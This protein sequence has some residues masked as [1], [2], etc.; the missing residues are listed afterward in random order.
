MFLNI[1]TKLFFFPPKISFLLQL[2]KP[3]CEDISQADPQPPMAAGQALHRAFARAVLMVHTSTRL[4]LHL[5][6]PCP[7][8]DLAQWHLPGPP[9]HEALGPTCESHRPRVSVTLP[10]T[11]I[12]K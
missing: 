12:R 6:N 1:V 9:Q 11:Q 2:P 5:V 10:T 4:P 7:P 3:A 8:Q